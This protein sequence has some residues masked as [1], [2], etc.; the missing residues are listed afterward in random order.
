DRP[1]E[2]EEKGAKEAGTKKYGSDRHE[3]H[4]RQ[5]LVDEARHEMARSWTWARSDRPGI[6]GPRDL[7]QGPLL[8]RRDDPYRS[9]TNSARGVSNSPRRDFCHAA[10]HKHNLWLPIKE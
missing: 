4:E 1:P 7:G 5:I 2:S 3:D 9:A 6:Y 10:V 8:R